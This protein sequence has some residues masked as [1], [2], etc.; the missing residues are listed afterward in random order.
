MTRLPLAVI[1][2]V[3]LLAPGL[4]S[5]PLVAQA[6]ADSVPLSAGTRVRVQGTFLGRGWHDGHLVELA[7]TGAGNCLAFEP[8]GSS[9]VAA[10]LL[11][12]SDSLEVW[13]PGTPSDASVARSDTTPAPGQWIGISRSRRAALSSGCR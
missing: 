4:T 3:P 6:G 9:R 2:A 8:A 12:A 5:N 13:V 7:V 11:N 1:I 10:M